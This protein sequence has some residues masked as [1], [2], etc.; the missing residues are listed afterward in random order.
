MNK[1][2]DKYKRKCPFCGKIGEATVLINLLCECGAK[3]YYESDIWKNRKTG[4]EVRG[5]FWKR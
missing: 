4:E 3:Y 5:E 2:I 1:Q